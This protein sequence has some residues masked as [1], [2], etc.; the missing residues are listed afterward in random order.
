[1]V[2]KNRRHHG[3]ISITLNEWRRP[4]R[5]A[6]AIGVAVGSV[7]AHENVRAVQPPHLTILAGRDHVVRLRLIG[8]RI[9]RLWGRSTTGLNDFFS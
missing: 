5:L 9:N 6:V 3:T 1:M 7:S 4:G 2:D 8:V